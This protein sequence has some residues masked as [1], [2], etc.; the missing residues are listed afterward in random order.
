MLRRA[1]FQLALGALR[2][3]TNGNAGH[4]I[5]D[6]TAINDCTRSE[7]GGRMAF[8]SERRNSHEGH[9]G[10]R[11]KTEFQ[12][13]CDFVSFVVKVLAEGYSSAA[14]ILPLAM[15]SEILAKS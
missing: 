5:N 4:A 14:R 15:T 7:F 11:R 12:P 6:I 2:Q 9:Q 3:L 13:S 1:D 8:G 10:T